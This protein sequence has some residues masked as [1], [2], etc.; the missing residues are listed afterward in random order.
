MDQIKELSSDGNLPANYAIMSNWLAQACLDDRARQT[1][2][3]RLY[4]K[5]TDKVEVSMPKPFV[6]KRS[7]GT[8]VVLGAK[9]ENENEW[10]KQNI[11]FEAIEAGGVSAHL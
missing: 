9:L 8:E 5:V 11:L 2:F 6:I 1:F 3:D 7:D 4:G 10:A